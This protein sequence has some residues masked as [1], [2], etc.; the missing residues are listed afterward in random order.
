VPGIANAQRSEIACDESGYEGERLI[1]SSTAAFAH[2]WVHLDMVAAAACIQTLRDRIRSPATE[3]KANHLLREKNRSALTW[4]LDPSGPLPEAARVWVLDKEL[5][6]L[7]T[8]TDMLLGDASIAA[9]FRR[10]GQAA[11]GSAWHPF[12]VAANDLLRAKRPTDSPLAAFADAVD[13]LRR[14]DAGG[15]VGPIVEKLA[16]SG[17][18][19]EAFRAALP[20]DHTRAIPVLDPLFPAI[21]AAVAA[22]GGD[23]TVI[24]DR[25]K[26]LTD[27]RIALLTAR[28]EALDAGRLAGLRLIESAI[29]P[30]VQVA[31]YLAGVARKIVSDVLRGR[32]DNELVALLAPYV[33][34]ASIWR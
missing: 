29:D 28:I 33:D 15:A 1:G 21:S 31:D 13:V 11:Y 32:G 22:Y 9:T 27:E 2:A 3:Y 24:H 26:T 8:L 12:L 16:M 17:D 18:A 6:V 10:S 4:F 23:V 25:Q 30:R 14:R 19:A 34:G 20:E 5:Y 7:R